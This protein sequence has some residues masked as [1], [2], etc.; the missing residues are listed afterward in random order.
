MGLAASIVEKV[1]AGYG[2]I[3]DPFWKTVIIDRQVLWPLLFS[4]L[5][6]RYSKK[7]LWWLIG[8]TIFALGWSY[9]ST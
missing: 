3:P 7:V 6:S 1:F 4:Y 5:F 2:D 9:F 8:G